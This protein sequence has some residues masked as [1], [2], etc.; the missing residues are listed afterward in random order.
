MADPLSTTGLVLQVAALLKQLYDYGT[1]VK[2]AQ[3]EISVLRSELYALKGVLQDIDTA[4]D[5]AGA[6]PSRRELAET[7]ASARDLLETLS[8]KLGGS[9]SAIGKAVQSVKW[10]LI[11][12]DYDKILNR[13]ERLKTWLILYS[14]SDSH[15]TIGALHEDLRDLKMTLNDDIEQRR[16]KALSETQ[17]RLLKT[18]SPPSLDAI[19]ARACKT[20]E[21]TS[22]GSWFS[23]GLLHDWMTSSSA[24]P[25]LVLSGKSGSGKT[26]V[27]SRAIEECVKLLHKDPSIMT[28]YC[29]CS[30]SDSSSQ[31]AKTI[32]GTW[33][34]QVASRL[35]LIAE[36]IDNQMDRRESVSCHQL[37]EHIISAAQHSRLF[38]LLDAM[39][40]SLE[41]KAVNQSIDRLTKD[42]KNISC[43]VSTIHGATWPKSECRQ[44]DM[45]AS[46]LL[47]DMVT[48]VDDQI[49]QHDVLAAVPR[50]DILAHVLGPAE[51]MFRWLEC[52]MI[53]LGTQPTPRLVSRALQSLPATL[54][55]TYESM[56]RRVPES[57][58]TLV[59][60]ALM[61]LT[62]S[63]RP[64]SLM[65]LNEAVVV[66]E[67]DT[68]IDEHS[69]LKP[70]DLLLTLCQG[71]VHFD[72]DKL[73]VTLAHHSV[74]RYLTTMD[75][76]HKPLVYLDELLCM[77]HIVRKCLTYLLMEHFSI[78]VCG[79]A[80]LTELYE[81]YPLLDYAATRWPL[82]AYKAALSPDEIDM[83]IQLF[84]PATRSNFELWMYTL[85]PEQDGHIA[86]KGAPLYYAAS[87]GLAPIVQELLDCGLVDQS[88][89]GTRKAD[90][91]G[92][93][94]K[95]G[96][97]IST[98][99]QVACYRGHAEIVD[100]LLSAGADPK[101]TDID[102]NTCLFWAQANNHHMCAHLIQH[103]GATS[104]SL[105]F[106]ERNTIGLEASRDTFP[107][108]DSTCAFLSSSLTESPSWVVP[109][110]NTGKMTTGSIGCKSGVVGD[111]STLP[112]RQSFKQQ[113]FR[114]QTG[115]LSAP[116]TNATPQYDWNTVKLPYRG[117]R[118]RT[119]GPKYSFL[120]AMKNATQSSNN[121]ELSFGTASIPTSALPL[122]EERI[123]DPTIGHSALS[124]VSLPFGTS[125][126]PLGRSRK[127]RDCE[128]RV[129][130][131][132]RKSGSEGKQ[133][134]RRRRNRS[135][136]CSEEEI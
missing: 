136:S 97:N 93:D 111:V 65:E 81:F 129:S 126:D 18:W 20:W 124:G 109:D 89:E 105:P 121:G 134:Q 12:S 32:L 125:D 16:Q 34:A 53:H 83:I 85:F 59:R 133:A 64:L 41:Q 115:T 50:E 55:Q 110:D 48:Y 27:M 82:H 68:C 99:L 47:P 69:R 106:D 101:S 63:H 94:Y 49:S 107:P 26:T 60:E 76:A 91:Y 35:P 118:D 77:R 11:K 4:Q 8:K 17:S 135:E 22:A 71:L 30:Y 38:L 79:P 24:P 36:K 80:K 52:Q 7:L 120:R 58:M 19:H 54:D 45:S 75:V 103:A 23:D 92:V 131:H 123:V 57:S 113:R 130:L 84:L 128:H 61:W 56:L 114:S 132:G 2:G 13:L 66:E 9:A 31:E 74:F 14:M 25:I 117:T 29:Y 90:F 44:V 72:T 87:Y 88:L 70:A 3:K 40:E 42:S 112:Y 1:A 15:A 62:F 127:H 37:E 73:S 43:V 39:N 122:G 10:P 100:I 104:P 46:T 98:A 95:C 116:L 33:L 67:G 51:G 5:V 96:R 86:R 6:R 108:A 21:G 119:R 28:A 78:G 102:G